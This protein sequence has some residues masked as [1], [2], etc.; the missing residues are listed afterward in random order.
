LFLEPFDE[1][2]ANGRREEEEEEEEEEGEA[3]AH[4]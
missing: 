4:F 3:R 1:L 2:R